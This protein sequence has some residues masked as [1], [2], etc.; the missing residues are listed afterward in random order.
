M[1]GSKVFSLEG[2]GLKLDT[3]ADIE[4]YIKELKEMNDVEEVRLLGNTLGIEASEALAKVLETKK[5]LQVSTV[6]YPA[7]VVGLEGQFHESGSAIVVFPLT[8]F[9]LIPP[10]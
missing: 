4:P 8:S 9:A 6:A 10:N 1:A 7:T 3:A 5:T 2:K